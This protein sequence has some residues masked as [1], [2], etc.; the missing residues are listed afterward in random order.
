M[1]PMFMLRMMRALKSA[2]SN[3]H[4]DTV[5]YLLEYGPHIHSRCESI[6][7]QVHRVF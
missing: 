4:L 1:V 2:V 7:Y 6:M 3:N 5:K